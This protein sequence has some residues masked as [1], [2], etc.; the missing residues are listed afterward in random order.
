[1]SV[2]P[3][4]SPGQVARACRTNRWAMLRL[5]R[6]AGLA[7]RIGGRW[8]VGEARLREG[9]P[10]VYERVFTWFEERASR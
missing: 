8:Y 9:L 7:E 10:E 2:P 4:L 3:Y 6:R 5:L 1:M